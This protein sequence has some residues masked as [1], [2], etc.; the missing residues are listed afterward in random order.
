MGR[1]AL[2]YYQGELAGELFESDDLEY[3]F[4]YNSDYLVK[5]VPLSFNL[6]LQADSFKSDHLFPFFDNLTSEGWMKNRQ[7]IQSKVDENDD[8]GLLIANGNDLLGAITIEKP[9]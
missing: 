7:S 6:P 3:S 4:T 1:L 9:E 8:F 5:G 2:V